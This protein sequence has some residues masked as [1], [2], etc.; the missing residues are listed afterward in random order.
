LKSIEANTDFPAEVI[1]MDNGGNPDDSDFL[2]EQARKGII[3]VYVR[4]RENMHVAFARNDGARIATGDYLAFV[5]NDIEVLPNWLSTC[6]GILKRHQDKKYLVGALVSYD[7][8]EK[9][10]GVLSDGCRVNLRSSL[11]CV[12]MS[13]EAWSDIGGFPS[14]RESMVI[15]HNTAIKKGWITVIPPEDYAIN[16]SYRMGMNFAY[17][18]TVTRQLLDGS[19]IHFEESD[20]KTKVIRDW[21]KGLHETI[22][23]GGNTNKK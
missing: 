11:E 13:R 21:G 6:V 5:D 19:K 18:M 22:R 1:L 17:R 7:K 23:V 16:H 3:N 12:V 8:K 20:Q 9:T 2:L 10:I 4:Y 15:W 14:H